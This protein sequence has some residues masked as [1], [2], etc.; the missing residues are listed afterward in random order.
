MFRKAV[1]RSL[2]VEIGS[3]FAVAT[4]MCFRSAASSSA[5]KTRE[6]TSDEINKNIADA[7]QAAR[8]F[9]IIIY[10]IFFESR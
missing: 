6:G 5:A 1:K 2:F 10:P 4:T 7:N 9:F 8:L 3:L